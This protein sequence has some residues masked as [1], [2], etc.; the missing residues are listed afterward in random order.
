MG[1]TRL[2]ILEELHA[3]NL[4]I[5]AERAGFDMCVA[6]NP[7]KWDHAEEEERLIKEQGRL[8]FFLRVTE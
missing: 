5:R 7:E 1:M 3:V 6:D 2:E 4:K 8:E